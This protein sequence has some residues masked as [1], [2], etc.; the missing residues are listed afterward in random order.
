MLEDGDDS[1]APPPRRRA[2]A[3]APLLPDRPTFAESA[4]AGADEDS[5]GDE[6]AAAH[7]ASDGEDANVDS[8]EA[9]AEDADANREDADAVAEDAD[10]EDK[11]DSEEKDD[12]SEDADAEDVIAHDEAARNLDTT[13]HHHDNTSDHSDVDDSHAR[14]SAKADVCTPSP[15]PQG[16]SRTDGGIIRGRANGN[17]FNFSDVEKDLVP[18]QT[19]PRVVGRVLVYDDQKSDEPCFSVKQEVTD[20]LKVILTCLGDRH[21]PVRSA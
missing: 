4:P 6:D 19:Q 10:S 20:N 14:L 18:D 13:M 2:A 8:A 12:D 3:V 16:A 7:T 15:K 9:E 21:S 17:V 5:D 11:A 1:V